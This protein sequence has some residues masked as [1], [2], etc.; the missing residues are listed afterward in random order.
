MD[1]KK[2]EQAVRGTVALPH[3]SGKTL[4]IAAVVTDDKVKAAKAAGA[5]A[6]GL[7][8]LIEEFGKGKVKYDIIVA[9]PATMKDLGKVAKVLGQKGMMPSPK[10]G[11]V[12]DDIE[13]TIKELIGGRIEYKNDKEGNVHVIFG[14]LSFKEEELENNLK[15]VLNAVK[16]AKP[17]G[18]KGTFINSI[19]VASS[20][21]PGIKL[22][23]NETLK[24]L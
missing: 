12:T 8:D 7:E 15:T 11:T 10:S 23:V 5:A 6:A 1:V 4:K 14:K 2:S 3:G 24:S 17:S 21:G 19:T 20:M 22:K 16:N 13:K 9:T 18:V